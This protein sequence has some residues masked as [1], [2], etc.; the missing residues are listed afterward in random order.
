MEDF[1]SSPT[2]QAL[3]PSILLTCKLSDNLKS[4]CF[5]FVGSVGWD[6][7]E[8]L[9]KDIAYLLSGFLYPLMMI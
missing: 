4:L 8:V 2:S 7:V 6:G 3:L 1:F 5:M 9:L